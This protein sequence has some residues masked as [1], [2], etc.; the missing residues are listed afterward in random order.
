MVAVPTYARQVKRME[1][2]SKNTTT[3]TKTY[4]IRHVK[5]SK[6]LEDLSQRPMLDLEARWAARPFE[7][8][9]RQQILHV[10]VWAGRPA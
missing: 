5:F 6:R 1:V 9:M 3:I 10:S 4:N 7:T 8:Q 2:S